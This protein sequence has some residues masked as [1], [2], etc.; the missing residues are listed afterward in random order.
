MGSLAT[1]MTA[2]LATTSNNNCHITGLYRHAVKGLS[3]DE[4]TEVTFDKAGDTFPDDR[5]F[6]LLQQKNEAKFNPDEPEWLHKEN[7][8]C[9][10]SAPALMSTFQSSYEL[11]AATGDAD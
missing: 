1:T 7:F 3:A 9:A 10:F 6:A 8:L 11:V 5:R 4:L 2:M